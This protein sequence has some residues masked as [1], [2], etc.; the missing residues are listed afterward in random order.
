MEEK[1]LRYAYWLANIRGVGEKITEKLLDVFGNTESVYEAGEPELKQ[2]VGDTLAERIVRS[3]DFW[4][5]EEEYR[6]LSETGTRFIPVGHRDYPER[7]SVIPG[8]P[9]AI[10]V[11]GE[12]PEESV[13]TGAMIGTRNCSRYGTFVA[14]EFAAA[15]A[16]AGVDVVS[17]MARGID[18]IC[19]SA[20]LDAGG[21]S[22]AVLGC[23]VDICYPPESRELYRR[24]PDRG[25]ILSA[26]PMGTVPRPEL[27]PPRNRIISGLSDFVLVVEA[28]LK[29]GTMITVDMALEQGRE[30]YVIPG[31]LT[32]RSSDGCNRLIQQGAG[33]V[34]SPEDLLCQ[35]HL[36]AV[37]S[38]KRKKK[39]N[40]LSGTEKKVLGVLDFELKTVEQIANEIPEMPPEKLMQ[41]L[42]QL[43]MK[44]A[45]QCIHG[46][47]FVK[48]DGAMQD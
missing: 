19:Q 42:I 12:L 10:Y 9:A 37:N 11:R 16:Q 5:P 38:R 45:A 6:K 36:G 28:S 15:L 21:R 33:I 8:K 34:L 35:L 25:G 32:D 2:I 29:S 41:F 24:L 22:Y 40:G 48:T 17:G 14:R 20:A 43:C 44:G 7:L 18:S 4:N 3:R 1:E 13:K 23:G 31:R 27:F 39:G 26:Y 30:V 47:Y 46:N